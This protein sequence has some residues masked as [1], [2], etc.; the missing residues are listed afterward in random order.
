MSVLLTKTPRIQA[1]RIT[2]WAE[3]T[4]AWCCLVGKTTGA[5]LRLN[6]DRLSV[7]VPKAQDECCSLYILR[8][9]NSLL[10]FLFSLFRLRS[11]NDIIRSMTIVIRSD[12]RLV[13]TTETP[14]LGKNVPRLIP[15]IKATRIPTMLDFI[16]GP[17][18]CLI[19]L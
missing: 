4:S 12:R 5:F 16:L 17:F 10:S 11:R 18:N 15:M 13:S 7:D 2:L 14:A 1:R 3:P 19:D 8:A 9:A 6:T